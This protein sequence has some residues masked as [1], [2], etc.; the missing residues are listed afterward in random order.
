MLLLIHP[1]VSY[2]GEAASEKKQYVY[3][4]AGLL[5]KEEVAKL[6]ESAQKYSAKRSTDIIILTTNDT[7]GKDIVPF[8]QDFY[9]EMALGY[10]KPHGNTAILTID[11]KNRDLYLAGFYKGK[12]YLDDRRLDSIRDKITPDLSSGNYFDAFH[13]FI[14]TSY[15]YMGIKP[16]V[17]PDNIL[18]NIWFQLLVSIGLAGI[19]VGMMAYSSGGKVTVN[20]KTYEA[21]DTSRVLQRRDQFIRTTTTRIKKPKNNNSGGGK[22][23]GFGGGISRGGH[24]HSGS[25][26]KF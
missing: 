24:S 23:G 25:R 9:D 22:G 17:N 19:V 14:K 4:F 16:G 7:N 21:T 3:D 20:E 2:K 12:T 26:G 13:T 8:M 6:E 1:V 10:D 5:E 15:K 18:F 11:M